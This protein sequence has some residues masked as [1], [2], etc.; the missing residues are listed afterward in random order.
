MSPLLT[1]QYAIQYDLEQVLGVSSRKFA[2][3]EFNS[4]YKSCFKLLN[5][6]LKKLGVK[7]LY[8]TNNMLND[9]LME[10]AIF[11]ILILA[12]ISITVLTA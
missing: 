2:E 3:T 6:E 7:S 5:S 1:P 4:D 12:R 8:C 9:A 10:S 11:L